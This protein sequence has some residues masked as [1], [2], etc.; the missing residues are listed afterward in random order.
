MSE[1]RD[2]SNLRVN[3]YSYR[4]FDAYDAREIAIATRVQEVDT[5]MNHVTNVR[6]IALEDVH[7]LLLASEGV[8]FVQRHV[9]TASEPCEGSHKSRNI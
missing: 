5:P 2:A 8:P 7:W 4:A 6:H 9:A 1:K 3:S